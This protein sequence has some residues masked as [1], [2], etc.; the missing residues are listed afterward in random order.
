MAFATSQ[1]SRNQVDRAGAYLAKIWAA[2]YGSY[3][4]DE[5]VRADEIVSNWRA[6]HCFPL[7]NFQTNLR[8][9]V[10]HI[11]SDV[12][13][14]QRIKR[15][16]SVVAKLRRD[17]T[18]TMEL[19]QMQDIGGCRAILRS[20]QNVNKLVDA[21]RRSKFAHKLRGEKN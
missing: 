1:Y 12:L 9:K 11:Q 16:E 19:S 17:Q 20:V 15:L 8:A 21:H 10:K 18:Q 13:V 5:M 2:D 7:N 6:S 3:D 14:A 4:Y